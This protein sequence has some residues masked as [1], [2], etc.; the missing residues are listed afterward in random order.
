MTEPF[1]FS[2]HPHRRRNPLTEDWV[3]VSPHRNKRPWQGQIEPAATH[4]HA[5]YDATCYLCP[6]NQRMS[7]AKN[8]HYTTPFVF[9]ND[10]PALTD[11]HQSLNTADPLFSVHAESGECRVVSYSP[12]HS[13]SLAELSIAEINQ[14]VACW[15]EQTQMLGEQFPWVQI[16]ENKGEMMGC[17][18][19]HPH[20]QIWAQSH[21]P[22]LLQ[23]EETTQRHY[24]D[25]HGRTLLLDYAQR[26][27]QDG[28][29]V[30]A[31]NEDWVAVVPFW[32]AWPFEIL[33]LPRFAVARL[34]EL[35]P[36]Q[37]FS[38]AQILGELLT[39]Y[40]NLFEC[41]FPYSMG[42]HS[43]PCNHRSLPHW[44]LHAHFYPP[45]L[46]SQNVRKFMVGYEMLAEAQRDLTPEQA[47]AILRAL[48]TTHYKHRKSV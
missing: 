11:A 7:G 34:T 9:N 17:S 31:D 23:R 35:T 19:P 28:N 46:R 42:W 45:L 29:R 18:M 37:G 24:H 30:V 2:N 36:T 10:F 12:D 14:V 8:P 20:G 6:G 3:L 4:A 27:L 33:L 48:P 40:D 22:S 39:R 5:K 38:L 16:F 47:A 1:N 25:E 43:G 32:A 15:I 21:T 13:R 26:E 41:S 44:Q